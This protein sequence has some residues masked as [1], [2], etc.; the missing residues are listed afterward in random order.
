MARCACVKP[1]EHVS[2][3]KVSGAP[4]SGR[5]LVRRVQDWPFRSLPGSGTSRVICRKARTMQTR[6]GL[7]LV[8]P[9]LPRLSRRES[10][11]AMEKGRARWHGPMRLRHLDQTKNCAPLAEM[12]EPLMK[13]ASSAT[14]NETQRAISSGSPRRPAGI[15]G[16]ITSFRTFSGTAITI[17]VPM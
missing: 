5:C 7:R 8:T 11:A 17:S 10:L 1:A 2:T 15:C 14:R 4:G 9:V 3:G 6:A 16:M 13:P 12:V